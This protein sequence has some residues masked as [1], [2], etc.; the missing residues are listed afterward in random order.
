MLPAK[1]RLLLFTAWLLAAS[2]A[3]AGRL[4]DNFAVNA[5]TNP[6][7]HGSPDPLSVLGHA[8]GR[9]DL[10][11]QGRYVVPDYGC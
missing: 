2:S 4:R 6:L 11:L 8:A 1:N 7:T 9:E 10:T 5:Q 3:N